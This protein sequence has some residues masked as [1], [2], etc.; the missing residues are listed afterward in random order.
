MNIRHFMMPQEGVWLDLRAASMSIPPQGPWVLAEDCKQQAVL[1]L[2][3]QGA[4]EQ[5]EATS[6]TLD[7]Q[8]S[9]QA[10]VYLT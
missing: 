4:S 6:V 7:A 5:P 9:S 10:H 2:P 1:V 3:Q 8:G